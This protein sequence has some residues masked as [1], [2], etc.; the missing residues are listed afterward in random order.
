MTKSDI[1]MFTD[2]LHPDAPQVVLR[3]TGTATAANVPELVDAAADTVDG[4]LGMRI[5]FEP[6][7]PGGREYS[8]SGYTFDDQVVI[9]RADEFAGTELV[10]NGNIE[11]QHGAYVV[12]GFF[13]VKPSGMH[14][15]VAS[16]GLMTVD[17]AA[18]RLSPKL[19]IVERLL[20]P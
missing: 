15:G 11:W 12:D 1:S 17:E 3:L 19:K 5:A 4:C 10:I 13:L 18:V 9:F 7:P 8:V 14:Q 2:M 16:F 20:A 6:T